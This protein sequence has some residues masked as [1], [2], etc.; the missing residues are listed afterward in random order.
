MDFLHIQDGG[1]LMSL[2]LFVLQYLE[3]DKNQACY[4][5][6]NNGYYLYMHRY[7]PDPIYFY[8]KGFTD[9]KH[10]Q[11]KPSCAS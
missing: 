7:V 9:K 8:I 5:K 6:F 2:S 10:L 4:Q 3:K 1:W 11:K